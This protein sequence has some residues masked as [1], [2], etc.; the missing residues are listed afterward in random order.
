MKITETF[1]IIPGF[2]E[3]ISDKQYVALKKMFLAKGFDVKMVPIVWHR[4]VMTDWV[5]QFSDFFEKH[6][7]KKNIVL[8]FSF[9]AM[10]ALIAAKNLQMSRLILCSL[11]PYFA[12]DLLKIPT[13]WKE[14]IGRRRTEDFLKYLAKDAVKDVSLKVRVFIGGAEQKKFSQLALRCTFVAKALSTSVIVVDGVKHDIGDKRYRD[15][16][17]REIL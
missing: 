2:K 13:R 3:K 8:G 14:Y 4:K 1:F 12:E 9:G 17:E 11:S 15:A 5:A 16:L 6:R 10:I 7:G